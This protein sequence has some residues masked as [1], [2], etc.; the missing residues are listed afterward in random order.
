MSDAVRS[1]GAR[2]RVLTADVDP[3]R[4][5]RRRR[6]SAWGAIFALAGTALLAR[7]EW[8]AHRAA[9]AT[10]APPAG[11]DLVLCLDVSRS[12]L[13]GD[14]RPTRLAQ[15][16]AGIRLLAER[17]R[18]D[19][20]ALIVFAGTARL[21]VPL[22]QDG[23]LLADL[24]E[25]CGPATVERGGSDLGAA[26]EAAR[27]AL[28]ESDARHA[29]VVLFTDGE[30]LEG[31]AAAAAAALGAD[32]IPVHA[33]G[34]GSERG[35]LITV[36]GAGGQNFLRDASGAEVV[37]VRDTASLRRIAQRSGGSYRDAGPDGA[38]VQ[39]LHAEVLQPASRAR[40]AGELAV[41]PSRVALA[42][43]WLAAALWILGCAGSEA[44]T[45]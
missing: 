43:L 44:R 17:S 29:A 1:L 41:R 34:Y 7:D 8:A 33:L 18:G 25:A 22:T 11:L 42:L 12:M 37:S 30:D 3:V 38:A 16:Q 39:E 4:R 13:A 27:A 32:G 26:L 21:H 19:R 35:S 2:A 10:A 5:R 31:R 23:A 36:D 24:A 20:T 15:A 45:R 6:A 14:A 9:A 40:F 28:A